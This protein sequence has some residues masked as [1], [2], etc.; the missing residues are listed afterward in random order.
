V[1]AAGGPSQPPVPQK[2]IYIYIYRVNLKFI[3]PGIEIFASVFLVYLT[4][5]MPKKHV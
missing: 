1:L 4:E 5:L 2:K 3:A